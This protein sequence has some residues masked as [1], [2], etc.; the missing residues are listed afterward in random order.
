MGS[1]SLFSIYYETLPE[2]IL[3]QRSYSRDHINL[4]KNLIFIIVINDFFD[5]EGV[6]LIKTQKFRHDRLNHLILY[7]D[8]YSGIL[9]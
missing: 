6:K 7:S 9:I 1:K 3:A 4:R 2:N 8:S 5:N